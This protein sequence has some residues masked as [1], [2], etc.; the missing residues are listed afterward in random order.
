MRTRSLVAALAVVPLFIS[1]TAGG[2]AADQVTN[3]LDATVDAFA[4]TM[5]LNVGGP[6][7]STDLSIVA[8]SD[9][10]KNGCNLTGQT[11]LSVDVSSSAPAVAAVSPSSLTFTKCG[12]IKTITVTPLEQGATTV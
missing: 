6:A 2:A 1:A 8:G 5:A 9:S 11:I 12:D 3:N 10:G 7:K 4:E